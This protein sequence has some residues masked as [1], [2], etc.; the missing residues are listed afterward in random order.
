MWTIQA[1]LPWMVSVLVCQNEG[2]LNLTGG[3]LLADNHKVIKGGPSNN[4]VKS[5]WP[6][7]FGFRVSSLGWCTSGLDEPEREV[8]TWLEDW[9]NY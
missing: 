6:K 8:G 9:E 1:Y 2:A 3:C 5:I 4:R 7:V